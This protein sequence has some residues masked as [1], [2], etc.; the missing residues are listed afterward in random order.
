MYDLCFNGIFSAA[1]LPV[2]PAANKAYRYGDGFFETLRVHHS[3]IPL[4]SF[5]RNRILKS[6][7]LLNYSFS[8]GVSV[9]LLHDQIIELCTRNRCGQSA[10]VRLSFSNGNGGIFDRSAMNYL[11][12]AG[13]LAPV[14]ASET[15]LIIGQY[16]EMQKDIHRFSGLKL[17]NALL[18]SRAAQFCTQQGWDD[19]LIQNNRHRVIESCISNLFWIRGKQLFTPPVAE[20]CVE[21]VFRSYLLAAQPGIREEACTVESLKAADELFLTNALRGIRSVVQFEDRTYT[22]HQTA[23]LFRQHSPLLFP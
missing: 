17:A 5:H 18:Y 12:E 13:P 7:D 1:D 23:A 2:I 11:I 8:A 14:N 10:R 22:G 15:G 21:G 4:W 9:S 20:G 6:M 3:A 16:H 19:C